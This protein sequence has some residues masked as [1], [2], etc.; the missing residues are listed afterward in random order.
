MKEII[1][2]TAIAAVAAVSVAAVCLVCTNRVIKLCDDTRKDAQLG[3]AN[4]INAQSANP[5]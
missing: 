5:V 3:F 2:V 1:L 4:A